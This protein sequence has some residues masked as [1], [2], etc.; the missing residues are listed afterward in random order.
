MNFGNLYGL[1]RFNISGANDSEHYYRTSKLQLSGLGRNLLFWIPSTFGN[2]SE[3]NCF[4]T[5]KIYQEIGLDG[6]SLSLIF[7]V[8]NYQGW[9]EIAIYRFTLFDKY[10]LI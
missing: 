3:A 10:G 6:V 5:L 2:I 7:H 4:V 9:G 1:Y 8:Y